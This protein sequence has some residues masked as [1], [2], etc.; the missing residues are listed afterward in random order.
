QR[1]GT[2]SLLEGYGQKQLAAQAHGALFPLPARERMKVRVLIQ[3]AI[4]RAIQ[5]SASAPNA[6]AAVMQRSTLEGASQAPA[7]SAAAADQPFRSTLAAWWK[8]AHW[9]LSPIVTGFMLTAVY[10]H[11]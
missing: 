7:P 6:S 4:M 11:L 1:F 3:R 5:D 2:S 8:P 9:A 10:P